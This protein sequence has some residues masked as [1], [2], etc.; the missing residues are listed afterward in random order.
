MKILHVITRMNYGGTAVYLN[1]LVDGL[2]E[3][4]DDVKL[5]AGVV[6]ANEEEDPEINFLHFVRISN[7]RRPL[8]FFRDIGAAIQIWR[9]IKGFKPEIIHSHTFKAGLIT[10]IVKPRRSKLVHTF[11]GHHL[12]DPEFQGFKNKMLILMEKLLT[13]RCDALISVGNRV[14]RELETVG[15]GLGTQFL[16]IPPGINP[17][18][19]IVRSESLRTLNL[20]PEEA[21]KKTVVWM[22]RFV[23]VK[24]PDKF[25]ELATKF[26]NVLFIMG[27][28]GPLKDELISNVPPNLKIVGWQPREHLLSLADIVISTSESEGMPLALIEAQMYGI[29]VIAPDVG[30]VSEVIENA[31]SGFVISPNLNGLDSTLRFLIERDELHFNLSNYSR[32]RAVKLFSKD[33]LVSAH[34]RLYKELVEN[35]V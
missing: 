26:P 32:A 16:S 6:E 21:T 33:T 20:L 9:Q 8:N 2:I 12:Y 15:I 34:R 28:D 23:K 4:G 22:G 1:N 35:H 19:S 18:V 11:H 17:P 27:G 29:P 7:L 31:K 24:R 5:L 3:R 14:M 13:K 25:V 30:S 10:R